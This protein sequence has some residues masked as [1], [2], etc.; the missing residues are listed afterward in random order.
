[1]CNRRPNHRRHGCC[2]YSGGGLIQLVVLRILYEKPSHGYQIMEQLQ[3]MT[4]EQYVPE[5]GALYTI[6][7]RM[8]N[9]S[10]VTSEWEKKEI[11]ADRRIYTLTDEGK[12]VLKEGLETVKGRNQLMENLSQ[13]YDKNFL[14]DKSE[15]NA[16]GN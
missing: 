2:H 7:R 11:G 12:Q 6:L 3:K 9:R 4:S 5:P 8:E 16:N 13:F 1:M 10:L 15:V 14:A